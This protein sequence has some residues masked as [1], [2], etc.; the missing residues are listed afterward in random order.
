MTHVIGFLGVLV[1]GAIAIVQT[2]SVYRLQR[3][4]SDVS[5]LYRGQ[6]ALLLDLHDDLKQAR[7]AA[8]AHDMPGI[9]RA[10][11][12]AADRLGAP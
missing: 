2:L 10:L 4:L 1:I 7:R 9:A 12:T 8:L 3:L 5:R 6:A 11:Q